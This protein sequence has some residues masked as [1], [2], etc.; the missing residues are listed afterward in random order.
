MR[1]AGRCGRGGPV[2]RLRSVSRVAYRTDHAP[3]G[4]LVVDADRRVRRS[5]SC[6]IDLA[7]GLACAAAVGDATDALSALQGAEAVDVCLIDPRLPEIEAG[8]A[9]MVRMRE[10]WPSMRIVAMSF[11]DAT[12][13]RALD[14]GADAFVAK[15]GQP[16]ALM[17]V[18]RTVAADR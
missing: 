12:E 8:I 16:D 18:I 10:R 4:V 6:L 15:S 7:D 11:S 2:G 13:H 9:L 17:E 3:I 5:L 14:G 1:T